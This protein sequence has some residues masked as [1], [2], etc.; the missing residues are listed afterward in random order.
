MDYK[1]LYEPH[2]QAIYGLIG[3]PVAHSLSPILHNTAFQ[4]LDVPI[5]YKLIPLD[6]DELEDFFEYLHQDDCPIFGVN[7]TV[8]YKEA[9]LPFLDS[10]APLADKVQAVNTIKVDSQRR[11]VGYNTDAP[12]FLAHLE[13]LKFQVADKNIAVLGAGGSSRALMTALC[14]INPGPKKIQIYNRTSEKVDHLIRD[15]SEKVDTRIVEPVLDVDSLDIEYTDLLI[16]TTSLGLHPDDPLLVDE[17]R[18]H[19]DLLVYDL[20]Y[21]PAETLLLRCA[22][23]QGARVANGLGMLYYQGVLAFE[24]WADQSLS[25]EIKQKMKEALF[26]QAQHEL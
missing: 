18:L 1:N 25:D 5:G 12:G 11:L 10:L 6:A 21:N 4:S 2:L 8:P 9:V 26:K 7:V 3:Q 15:L 22:R 23:E 24:H 16:N 19:S 14:L 17:F 13:E 20:I